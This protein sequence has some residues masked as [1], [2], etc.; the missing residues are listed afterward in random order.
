MAT[1]LVP[2]ARPP[3]SRFY[4]LPFPSS[5]ACFC[6]VPCPVYFYTR[7]QNPRPSLQ[8]T[9]TEEMRERTLRR[10]ERPNPYLASMMPHTSLSSSNSTMVSVRSMV[11]RGESVPSASGSGLPSDAVVH[12]VA[13][14]TVVGAV[15]V[16]VV[17]IVRWVEGFLLFH[18]RVIVL[19]VLVGRG[20]G[21]RE[22]NRFLDTGCSLT[23]DK[24]LVSCRRGTNTLSGVNEQPLSRNLLFSLEP[25]PLPTNTT[26][27]MTLARKEEKS[28]D[29]ANDTNAN[30]NS[31]GPSVGFERPTP[32]LSTDLLW[33]LESCPLPT[34]TTMTVTLTWNKTNHS[35]HRTTTTSTATAPTTVT[36][37]TAWTTA[38]DG[39]PDPDALGTDPPR[40]T[41]HR[42]E[43]MVDLELDKLA[44]SIIDENVTTDHGSH[45]SSGDYV[46]SSSAQEFCVQYAPQIGVCG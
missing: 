12:A 2:P 43:T 36:T 7:P 27:T 14:V 45:G 40:H 41:I 32:Y 8:N 46:C 39:N 9:A 25:C 5:E 31:N 26:K 1:L 4:F 17:V 18:A 23:P 34:R 19:V 15:A 13:V 35:T 28:F 29:P 20:H 6:P 37:A 44:S 22:S 33:S 38:S 42:T 10:L 30:S 21:S 16:G 11:C 24:G 3:L